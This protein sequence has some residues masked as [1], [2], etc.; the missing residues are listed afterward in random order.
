MSLLNE[1]IIPGEHGKTFGTNAIEETELIEIKSKLLKIDGINDVQINNSIFPK[2]FTV[3]TNKVI[4]IE[5]IEKAVKSIGY[6]AIPKAI[7]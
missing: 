6:H 2:E 4:S 3:F 1:N 5:D 7:I